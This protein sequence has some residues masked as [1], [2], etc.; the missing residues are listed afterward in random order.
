MPHVRCPLTQSQH[1]TQVAITASSP[2]ASSTQPHPPAA[3]LLPKV[4][5]LEGNTGHGN[6]CKAA[7]ADVTNAWKLTPH[8][9]VLRADTAPLL[10]LQTGVKLGL[11]EG[12]TQ[13]EGV[14]EQ[15]FG[16]LETT[17]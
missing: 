17:A 15:A 11:S 9:T 1:K 14:T 6:Y 16:R 7:T 2:T 4:P 5:Y 12:T 13:D 10:L 3:S 8:D